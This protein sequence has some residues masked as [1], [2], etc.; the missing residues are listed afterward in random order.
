MSI[1]RITDRSLILCSFCQQHGMIPLKTG[2][3]GTVLRAKTAIADSNTFGQAFLSV[4]N[5]FSTDKMRQKKKV[6]SETNY[7]P[8]KTRFRCWIQ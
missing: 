7:Y 1:I 6:V 8:S 2:V 3:W 5:A 4:K